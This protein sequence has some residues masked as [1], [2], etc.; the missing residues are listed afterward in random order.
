MNTAQAIQNELFLSYQYL[1]FPDEEKKTFDDGYY[2]YLHEQLNYP[3]GSELLY[4]ASKKQFKTDDFHMACDG[5]RRTLTILRTEFG[6]TIIAY[7][8]VAWNSDGSHIADYDNKS[9]II[10]L[11]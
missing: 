3:I 8:H 6:K 4:K 10:W 11:N 7:A 5:M 9:C 2:K 1:A